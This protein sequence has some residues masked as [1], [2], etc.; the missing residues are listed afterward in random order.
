MDQAQ[1]NLNG[2]VFQIL[3]LF[4]LE[5]KVPKPQEVLKN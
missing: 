5:S 3:I 4:T 1:L 2:L